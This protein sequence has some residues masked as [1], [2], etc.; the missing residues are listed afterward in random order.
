M[1]KP[2]LEDYRVYL[3]TDPDLNNNY[4]VLEQVE[5]A[6][7]AGVKII[8][9]RE[10][11]LDTNQFI[12]EAKAAKEITSSLG[13]YLIINDNLDVA[14]EIDADGIHL[15][16]SDMPCSQARDILSPDKVIGI[17]VTT[18]D[19]ARKAEIDGA[20]Y[21]AANGVFSTDT[22]VIQPI[23]LAGIKRLREATKLPLIA[24]GGIKKGNATEVITA[25]A[26][27]I[28]VVTAITM[29]DN[30]PEACRE[31]KKMVEKTFR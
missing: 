9:I 15:G 8:Q 13:S 30:I 2:V 6:A 4:T 26:D 31:L 16:Q 11:H 17:S 22:K 7:K 28:A 20:D 24:I 12:R 19:E 23:G 14:L 27:G 25:G 1:D 5:Y 29:A 10:K 18:P 3:V 21:I